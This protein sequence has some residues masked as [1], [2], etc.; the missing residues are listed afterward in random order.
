MSRCQCPCGGRHGCTKK[1]VKPNVRLSRKFHVA[2]PAALS[3]CQPCRGSY[4]RI[5]VTGSDSYEPSNAFGILDA[6]FTAINL[7]IIPI[8]VTRDATAVEWAMERG[9]IA[10]LHVPYAGHTGE[11]IQKTMIDYGAALCIRFGPLDKLAERAQASGIETHRHETM[12]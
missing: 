1:S 4:F 5:I 6:E 7:E 12:E 10:E 8:I 11:R 2:A 3:L 9:F